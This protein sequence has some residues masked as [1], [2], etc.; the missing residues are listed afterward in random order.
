MWGVVAAGLE[1]RREDGG[2][3]DKEQQ[4]SDEKGC[5]RGYRALETV[6]KDDQPCEKEYEGD[7][8]EEWNDGHD[9]RDV[10]LLQAV[11]PVLTPPGDLARAPVQPGVVL[12]D[13]LLDDDTDRRRREAEN[14]GDELEGVHP[15]SVGWCDELRGARDQIFVRRLR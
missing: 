7:E 11:Q 15:D 13:P 12:L 2:G 8:K 10:P 4:T 3:H 1:Y 14:Q 6:K 5:N 9:F